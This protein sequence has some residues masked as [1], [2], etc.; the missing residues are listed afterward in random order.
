VG[1]GAGAGP[2]QNALVIA[3]VSSRAG[4]PGEGPTYEPAIAAYDLRTGKLMHQ[5]SDLGSVVHWVRTTS[6]GGV[7]VGLGNKVASLN[8]P[9]GRSNWELNDS[10][11]RG[12]NAAW[13]VGDRVFVPEVAG[14]RRLWLASASSGQR[15]DLDVSGRL[16]LPPLRAVATSQSP[17][18]YVA[19]VSRKGV[20]VL[21]PTGDL[22]GLDPF[23][24]AVELL[25]PEVGQDV[26]ATIEAV[27]TSN[28]DSP[29]AT[30][31]LL[32]SPGGR[33]I[34]SAP[35]VMFEDPRE[36]MLIDGHVLI[37]CDSV[38]LSI[39]LPPERK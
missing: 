9:A 24:G 31:H 16:E 23:N 19:F 4:V 21:G 2:G 13:V 7:I 38:T 28:P 29:A 27:R 32:E 17:D 8:L 5:M 36:L 3:G 34:A 30:L 33:L 37:S 14:G 26:M 25:A 18:A 11:A 1:P 39:P 15:R 6:S 20:A 12:T 35:V 10:S 22:A